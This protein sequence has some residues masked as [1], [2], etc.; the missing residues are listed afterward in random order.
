MLEPR[1]DEHF[2]PE[3]KGPERGKIVRQRNMARKLRKETRGAIK[4]LRKD[5]RFLSRYG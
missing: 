5:A 4:E 2:N 3:N 1:F